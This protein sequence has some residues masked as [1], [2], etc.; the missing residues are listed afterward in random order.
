[1]A[2][3]EPGQQFQW[4]KPTEKALVDAALV[5]EMFNALARNN[6]TTDAAYPSTPRSGM[7]RINAVDP[8]NI[9]LEVWLGS[10]GAWRPALQ[11]LHVGV[12]APIKQLVQV[13]VA[14]P[15]WT[16]DHNLGS[17]VIALVFDTAFRQSR[18]AN[19]F[20]RTPMFL[21]RIDLASWAPGPI[22]LGIPTPFDGQIR[23]AWAFTPSPG[24]LGAPAG[25]L[26]L[27]I[28]GAP[29]LGG[30]IIVV[31]TPPGVRT[32]ATP[33]VG[34]NA[35]SQGND[36]INLTANPTFPGIPGDAFEVWVELEKTLQADEYF[37]D[38][39]TEN[40]IVV[41]HSSPRQGWVV[42]IG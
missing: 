28:G 27:D 42:L 31:A 4:D 41:T 16:I 21:G 24:I 25:T 23:R 26:D 20:E 14:S 33:I 39:P 34:A 5:R 35:F 37:L 40:R 10:P 8:N 2:I 36:D 29:V 32:D 22:R 12:P 30:Q 6:Y 13:T 1:M 38:Q 11:N 9:R 3:I 15:V 18:A 17:R 19:T 7:W